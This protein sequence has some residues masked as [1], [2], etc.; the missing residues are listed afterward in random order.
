MRRFLAGAELIVGIAVLAVEGYFVY[1]FYT[2]PETFPTANAAPYEA[3][4][5]PDAVGYETTNRTNEARDRASRGTVS[6]AD[7]VFLQEATPDNSLGNS[8]YLDH[9][10]VDDNPDAVLQVNQTGIRKLVLGPTMTTP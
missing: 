6:N 8:T 4:A 7:V 9:P 5:T 10:L 2:N 1:W 3:A